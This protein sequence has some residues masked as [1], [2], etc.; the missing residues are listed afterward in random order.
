MVRKGT[1]MRTTQTPF[2]ITI[3]GSLGREWSN[4]LG[5]LEI[6]PTQS[7]H[8]H[9]MTI[10]TGHLVDQ[11]DLLGVLNTLYDL[12]LPIVSVECLAEVR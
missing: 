5:G 6:V 2:R 11:A 12:H 8:G 10:L 1:S 3:N 4:R 9:P 7:A